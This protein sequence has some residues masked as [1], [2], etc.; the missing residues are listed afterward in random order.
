MNKEIVLP[1]KDKEGLYYLSYSQMAKWRKSKRDYIR[2]YFFGEPDDN[3]GLQRYGDFGHKVG[4]AFE[5]NDF[6]K[7]EINE[8]TFLQ[9]IPRFDEFETEVKLEMQGFYVLGYVDSNTKVEDGY[10]KKLLDYKTGDIVARKPEY[11]SVEYMQ[12][13]IYSAA[14]MQ[15]Y[16]RLPDE[17][18]VVLIGRSG[19]AFKGEELKLTGEVEIIPKDISAGR[20]AKV[21]AHVQKIAEEIS[22]CYKAYLK[23]GLIKI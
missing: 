18:S 14:F 5:N 9:T 12:T 21:H 20:V 7:F 1:K 13:E 2:K 11:E 17:A 8:Q 16:G 6:S 22:D 19:N 3:A 4:E 23:L 15:K 10:V